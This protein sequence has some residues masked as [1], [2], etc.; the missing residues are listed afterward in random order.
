MQFS[1]HDASISMAMV[2][3]L[4]SQV[5]ILSL[6]RVWELFLVIGL[7][8]LGRNT[9]DLKCLGSGALSMLDLRMLPPGTFIR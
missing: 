3:N 8:T 7:G 9:C 2:V 1:S 5:P 4:T 6:H